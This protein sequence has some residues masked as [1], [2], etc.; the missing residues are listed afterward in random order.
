LAPLVVEEL[1]R[2]PA[3]AQSRASRRYADRRAGRGNWRSTSPSTP[4]CLRRTDVLAGPAREIGKDEAVRR[5]YLG[6]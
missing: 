3:P 4:I 2:E 6:Y 1:F 5:S